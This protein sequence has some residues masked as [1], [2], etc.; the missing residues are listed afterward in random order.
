MISFY[1]IYQL[2]LYLSLM[3]KT[4]HCLHLGAEAVMQ[5]LVS[6]GPSRLRPTAQS[7]SIQ[8]I[9]LNNETRQLYS[10]SPGLCSKRPAGP[11][12]LRIQK[13]VTI[14][15]K[16]VSFPDTLNFP[17]KRAKSVILESNWFKCFILFVILIILA[18]WYSLV[19][20][21]ALTGVIMAGD[22]LTVKQVI[23]WV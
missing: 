20:T 13:L 10:K 19:A 22:C 18:E 15:S 17:C 14:W 8:F 21:R 2:A 9:F 4:H 1:F 23:V 3:L 7:S 16:K 6:S 11:M 5:Q 12:R